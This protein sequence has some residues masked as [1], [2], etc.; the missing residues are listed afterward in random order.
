M[1]NELLQ[2]LGDLAKSVPV[3]GLEVRLRTGAFS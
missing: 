1:L 2:L 3:R